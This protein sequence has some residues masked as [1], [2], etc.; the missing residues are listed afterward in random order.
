MPDTGSRTLAGLAAV[1][2]LLA[3]CSPA[4]PHPPP[5]AGPASTGASASS[6]AP[7]VSSAAPLPE[8]QDLA[9]VARTVHS[10]IT[11]DRT[12]AIATDLD[13]AGN[14]STGSGVIRFSDTGLP[15][16][17]VTTALPASPGAAAVQTRLVALGPDTYANFARTGTGSAQWVRLSPTGSDLFTGLLDDLTSSLRRAA[18]P[19]QFLTLAASGGQITATDRDKVDAADAVRYSIHVDVAK[20]ERDPAAMPVAR[21]LLANGVAQVDFQLWVGAA[22]RP[23]RLASSETLPRFGPVTG[24]VDFTR[25]GEPVQIS[26]PPVG[27]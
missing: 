2:A 10:R 24:H 4:A 15:D 3:G 19:Q 7:T 16:L 18:D 20:A 26:A 23:L 8:R 5:P 27:R 6:G 25:W 21:E 22:D 12:A 13:L 17:D 1:G 9:D 11:Q 14:R